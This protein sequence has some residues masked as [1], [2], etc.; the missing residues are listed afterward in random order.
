MINSIIRYGYI[1]ICILIP[2]LYLIS[3]KNYK[4]KHKRWGKA[5][6]IA[7]MMFIILF[8]VKVIVYFMNND[9]MNCS[10]NN[11]C[12]NSTTT[13]TTT[14]NTS[15]S[16]T[17]TSTTTST[18]VTTTLKKV[19]SNQKDTYPALSLPDGE[20]VNKGT[21]KNGNTIV[22]VDGAYYV[23]NVLIANKTYAL[24]STF[25][26]SNTYVSSLN[27]TSVCNECINKTAYNAWLDMKSDAAALGLNIWI[28]SGYRPYSSQVTIYNRYVE[29]D[30]KDKAD[31]YSARPGHSE[32]QTGLS[33]DLNSIS[34]AFADTKEGKWVNEN[35][36]LYGFC[37]RFPKDK[38]DYTGYKYESWHLRYVGTELA[39]KLYNNGDWISLEEYFGITSIY[40]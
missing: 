21:T 36:Y 16:S 12:N 27:K 15:S 14:S 1:F 2:V 39:T 38:Q 20:I 6:I 9:S 37:I 8:S 34:D 5:F 13:I 32:H 17:T 7:L 18:T 29:R 24:P 33:F 3:Y 28:Q 26:P 31:T 19:G 4:S 23:D 11:I 30:G 35:A 10:F 40:E 22:T 25:V